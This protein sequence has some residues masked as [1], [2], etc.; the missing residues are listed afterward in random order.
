MRD[1]GTFTFAKDA[2]SAREI[3]AMLT[4]SRS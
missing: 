1:H 3:S 4:Q 2:A